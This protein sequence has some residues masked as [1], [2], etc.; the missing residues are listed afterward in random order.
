MSS[1]SDRF[2]DSM[3]MTVTPERRSLGARAQRFSG[4]RRQCQVGSG[5]GTATAARRRLVPAAAMVLQ[6][7]MYFNVI[8]I[9]FRVLCISDE[10]L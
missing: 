1:S 4:C 3:A 5:K 7:S 10:S 6:L 8:F 9:M 2:K